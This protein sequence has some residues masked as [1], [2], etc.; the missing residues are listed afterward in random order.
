[1]KPKLLISLIALGLIGALAALFAEYR[2]IVRLRGQLGL[3]SGAGNLPTA[4]HAEL[5]RIGTGSKASLDAATAERV[6]AL[7]KIL[8]LDG[9]NEFQSLRGVLDFIDQ[10]NPAD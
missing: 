1:M 3:S 5:V 2:E 9:K 8:S 6:A 10:L 4:G 7:G